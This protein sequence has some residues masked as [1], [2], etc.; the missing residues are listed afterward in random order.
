MLL[1]IRNRPQTVQSESWEREDKCNIMQ[2]VYLDD[3]PVWKG[4]AVKIDLTYDIASRYLLK[5]YI[6]VN[7]GSD[8][9]PADVEGAFFEELAA[10]GVLDNSA[11]ADES[12]G[13][14][15]RGAE[16]AGTGTSN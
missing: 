3:S 7:R 6:Q 11:Q 8:L 5:A 4:E 2:C 10:H 1:C 13:K 16:T 15:Q 12:P 14:L 9:Q